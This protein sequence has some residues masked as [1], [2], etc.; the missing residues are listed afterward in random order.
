[1]AAHLAVTREFQ[2]E[3]QSLLQE[4]PRV[5]WTHE[6]WVRAEDIM[7]LHLHANKPVGCLLSSEA[8]YRTKSEFT[9]VKGLSKRAP[10]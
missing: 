3:G 9:R 2:D 10:V 6:V 7:R 8:G 5:F 4:G 1:M